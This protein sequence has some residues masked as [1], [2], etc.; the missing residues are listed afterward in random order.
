MHSGT[1]QK[2]INLVRQHAACFPLES[3][4][5]NNFHTHFFKQTR[6]HSADLT[7]VQPIKLPGWKHHGSCLR[8]RCHA[9]YEVVYL[10]INCVLV[11]L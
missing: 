7:S 6:S 8:T 4:L 9:Y 5:S 3:Q 1:Y 10:S 2:R 11:S